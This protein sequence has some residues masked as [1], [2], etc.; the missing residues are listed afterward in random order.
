[1]E[2]IHKEKY[3]SNTI[4]FILIALL[5]YLAY[6]SYYDLR[7]LIL[8]IPV[9]IGVLYVNYKVKYYI[10]DEWLYLKSGFL[11]YR[12]I[13]VFEIAAILIINIPVKRISIV[14]KDDKVIQASLNNIEKFTTSL[15]A[16]NPNI[17]VK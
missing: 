16:I 15:K 5:V 9:S 1:M 17:E 8:L 2:I 4:F 14:T 13:D 6:S 11:S 7:Y 10:D 12:E 3:G